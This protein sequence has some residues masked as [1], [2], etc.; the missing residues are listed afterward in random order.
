MYNI[1]PH[2][3][4][5]KHVTIGK[6]TYTY[7]VSLSI[8]SNAKL[9]INTDVATFITTFALIAHDCTSK[10]S[11]NFKFTQLNIRKMYF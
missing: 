7:Y 6:L 11:Q 2:I 10:I 1:Q 9:K 5:I 8:I 4:Y 3:C